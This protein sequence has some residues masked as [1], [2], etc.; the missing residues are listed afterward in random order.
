MAH[1]VLTGH[2]DWLKRDG[3]PI[4]EPRTIQ[5]IE[6]YWDEWEDWTK[7]GKFFVVPIALLPLPKSKRFNIVMDENL[8]EQVDRVS[9]NRS[10]FISEATR[11]ALKGEL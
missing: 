7:N 6:K 8:M 5:E 11:K 3:D 2:I 4:P 10:A 9:K 1:E